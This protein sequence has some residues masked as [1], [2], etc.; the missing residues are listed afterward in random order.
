MFC[1][2]ISFNKVYNMHT[3]LSSDLADW[4]DYSVGDKSKIL[5]KYDDIN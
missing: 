3:L 1:L 2:T 4:F 5:E